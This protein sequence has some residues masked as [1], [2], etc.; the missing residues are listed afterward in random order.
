MLKSEAMSATT[1]PNSLDMLGSLR[2]RFVEVRGEIRKFGRTALP[3][4]MTSKESRDRRI[5]LWASAEPSS[6]VDP[7]ISQGFLWRQA[8]VDGG[9]GWLSFEP[10]AEAGWP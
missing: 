2:E 7:R 8:G 10:F 6:R 1:S 5:H 9:L 3:G 4:E